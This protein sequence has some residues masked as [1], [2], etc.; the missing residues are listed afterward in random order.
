MFKMGTILKNTRILYGAFFLVLG[1]VVASCNKVDYRGEDPYADAKAPLAI[2]FN[3]QFIQPESGGEGTVVTLKGEGFEKYKDSGLQVAINGIA[4]K[5]VEIGDSVLKMEMPAMASTGMVT[6][7]VKHQVFPGPYFH[8]TG[9]MQIDPLFHALP[10]ADGL[11]NCIAFV[12]GGQYLIGGAFSDYGNS[13]M[14]Y[15]YRGLARINADGTLDRSFNIGRG[16]QGVV[17]AV[18]VLPDGRYI[19]GG[20]ISNYNERFRQGAIANITRLNSDGSIDSTIVV[21]QRSTPGHT[22]N[23]TIPAF[24]AYFDGAVNRVLQ[25]PYDDK[26]VVVG[27]FNFFMKKD[28]TY[29]SADGLRDSVRVDS[30]RMEGMARLDRAGNLDSTFNFNLETQQGYDGPNGP[31]TDALML[32][33]GKILI[34]GGFTRYRNQPV[35]YIARLNEDGSLDPTFKTDEGT[36]DRILSAAVLPDGRYLI[37]GQFKTVGGAGRKGIALLKKDG[38]LDPSFD[39][40]TAPD[41]GANGLILHAAVLKNDKILV[42]GIFDHF[43]GYQRNGTVVLNMD[44]TMSDA[45]NNLGAM[46]PSGLISDLLN[47]PNKNA[48]ILVGAFTAFDLQPANRIVSINY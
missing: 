9:L 34:V 35:H 30:I 22:I 13:G 25:M 6:L 48:T 8:V 18:A 14:V 15:G 3:S 21:S 23:D 36:D 39:V 27:D 37:A 24:R 41:D 12:P 38:S 28:F 31:V 40:G 46:S 32:S 19:I 29:A 33:D 42:S 10:G 16:V 45:Y 7:K 47:V 20:N 1:F 4:G 17:N 43:G 26:L 44:G 11:I 5:I 2:Q